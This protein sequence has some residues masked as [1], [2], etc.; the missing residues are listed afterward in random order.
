[1]PTPSGRP[2]GSPALTNRETGASPGRSGT[3]R[4]ARVYGCE[5][6]ANAS[7]SRAVRSHPSRSRFKRTARLLS[8]PL[9]RVKS[10][11]APRQLARRPPRA[12]PRVAP[13]PAGLLDAL[14]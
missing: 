2:E 4:A 10:A 12:A 6:R 1:M 14:P 9:T 7:V 5:A 11:A 3:V 13:R 8:E